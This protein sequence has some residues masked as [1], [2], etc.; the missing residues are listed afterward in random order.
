MRTPRSI[1]EGQQFHDQQ[2]LTKEF[3]VGQKVLLFNSRLKFVA[4]KLRSRW[5]EPFVIT[6]VNGQQIKLFHEGPAPTVG[7]K[8]SISLMES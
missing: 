8:E 5:D 2:I 1:V 4:S 3:Q 7:E 6:N